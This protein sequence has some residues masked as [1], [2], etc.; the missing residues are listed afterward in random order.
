MN[1]GTTPTRAAQFAQDS[2]AEEVEIPQLVAQV[3]EVAPEAERGRLLEQ[4]LRPLGVLSLVAVA[5]GIFAKIR[6]QSGWQDLSVRIDDIRGV[7]PVDIVALVEHAQQVSVEAV[8][9][10]AQLL[11]ASPALSTS[12]TAVLLAALLAGRARARSRREA[13]RG[14]APEA[15]P[16]GFSP[17]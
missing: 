7:R 13:V 4:L 16:R 3:Y 11:M 10:L 8:D 5:G 9:G 15:R 1:T 6:F 2:S 12:A 17:P 14:A